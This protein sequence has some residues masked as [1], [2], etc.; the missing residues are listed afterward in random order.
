MQAIHTYNSSDKITAFF[1]LFK[2][3]SISRK[4][5]ATQRKPRKFSSIDIIISFWKLQSIGEPKYGC[6][7]PQKYDMKKRVFFAILISVL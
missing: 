6:N 7:K 4:I 5:G 1:A 3:E 2:A